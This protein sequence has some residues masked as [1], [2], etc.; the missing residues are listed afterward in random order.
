M[1]SLIALYTLGEKYCSDLYRLI[2]IP[3][4]SKRAH[5]VQLHYWPVSV[6]LCV[7]VPVIS[8]DTNVSDSCRTPWSMYCRKV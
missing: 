8:R 2:R 1:L 6:C 7:C 3:T 4:F 5:E